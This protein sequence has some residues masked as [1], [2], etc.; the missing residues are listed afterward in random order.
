MKKI[1]DLFQKELLAVSGFAEDTVQTY[2]SSVAAFRD[3]AANSLGIDPLAAK[4]CHLL[5]WLQSIRNGISR[6]RLRQHQFAIKSFFAFLDRRGFVE[7]N[8]AAALPRIG[9]KHGDKNTAVPADA[10]FKLLDA[11]DRDTWL[12]QR[13]HLIIAMLWS[14]GLR[15]S[16][17]TG[18][19]V[20]SFEPLHDPQKRIGLL[21]VRGKNKKQRALFVVGALYDE[22]CDYLAEPDSPKWKDQPLFPTESG[23][24]VSENRIQKC[25]GEYA[26]KA[27]LEVTV[28]PHRLRHSFATEMY[29]QEV[30][31]SSIQAMLGHS[32]KS[33]TAIYI[34][35]PDDMK[36]RAMAAVGIFG[37]ASCR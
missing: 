16:E 25:L 23:K 29:R 1:I 20:G 28:T 7:K 21:R 2:S 9:A 13:N 22:L 27:G 3:F 33:E 34:H 31:P 8:P 11:V 15:I 14:L 24:A 26:R 6:S 5:D 30:P 12:G 37:G 18:L 36:K 19:S 10:V 4:G 32:R 35:I 17:L